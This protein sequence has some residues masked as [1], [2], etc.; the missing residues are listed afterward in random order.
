MSTRPCSLPLR[1]FSFPSSTKSRIIPFLQHKSSGII[2]KYGSNS[3]N[4][5]LEETHFHA[6]RKLKLSKLQVPIIE[7]GHVQRKLSIA[8]IPSSQGYRWSHT[9]DQNAHWSYSPIAAKNFRGCLAPGQQTAH[10]TLLGHLDPSI[11]GGVIL[12]DDALLARDCIP[13][14][15]PTERVH[16]FHNDKRC[17]LQGNDAQMVIFL[18]FSLWTHSRPH[19]VFHLQGLVF[20]FSHLHRENEELSSHKP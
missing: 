16:T 18:F 8:V 4:T 17:L 12:R 19:V 11:W 15:G 13:H 2:S 5:S 14:A 20:P 7:A 1:C 9:F 10:L 6:Q 3:Q